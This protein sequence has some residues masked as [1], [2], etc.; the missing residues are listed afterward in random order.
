MFFGRDDERALIISNL[1][2]ARL[3]L[4]YAES[5]VGKTSLLRAGVAARLRTLAQRSVA[6][7]GSAGYVPVVFSSWRDDPTGEFVSEVRAAIRPFASGSIS[8]LPGAPLHE[9]IQTAA[10]ATD[11]TLLVILDQFEEYLLYSSREPRVGR[12]ADELAAC[13]NRGDLRA[14]FLIAVREDAYAGLG[15]LFLGKIG[16]LYGNYL[17]LEYLDRQAARHA[18]VRPIE[19]FNAAHLDTAPVQIEPALVDAVLDQVQTG[20][21]AFEHEGRG[22]LVFGNGAAREHDQI[23]TPYLQLVMSA[24][25]EHE[26]REGSQS[27]R[28][29]T[30]IELGGAERIVRSH[31]EEA[32]R[33]L[34]DEERDTAVE[35]FNHLVTPGGT[36]IAHTISDLADYSGRDFEQ[37]QA[38]IG[39]LA[40]GDQRILRPVPAAPGDDGRPRVEIFHDVLA[41]AILSWRSTQN[42]L[43]LEREKE[44]AEAAAGRERRRAQLFRA[45]ALAVTAL[46]VVA[47]VLA[48]LARVETSRAVR[49]QHLALSRQL[50]AAALPYIQRGPID[51]GALLSLEAFH[52]AATGGAR[53]SLVEAVQATAPII[54]YLGGHAAAVTSVAVS[55]NGKLIASVGA[56]GTMLIQDPATGRTEHTFRG[57]NKLWSVA[58]SPDGALLVAG[59]DDGTVTLW[60]V[61]TGRL[62][63][64]LREDSA[65]VYAVAFSPDAAMVASGGADHSVVLWDVRSGRRLR[66]LQVGRT[67]VDSVAFSP[68][69][70]TLASGGGDGRVI[71][72]GLNTGQPAHTL[73]RSRAAV[74]SVAFA[75]DGRT[76]ASAGDDNLVTLWN[77]VTARRRM[78]LRGQMSAVN[79]V[80]YSPDGGMLAAA[81]AG[82]AVTVWQPTTGRR[83]RTFSGQFAAIESVAFGPGGVL[84]SGGDDDHVIIW[85][86]QPASLERTLEENSQVAGVAFSPDGDVIAAGAGDA[87]TLRSATTGQLVRTFAGND[88]AVE[89]V[90]F[91]PDGRMLASANADSTVTLWNSATG[92]RERTLR[93]HTDFV[94]SVA[95]SPDGRTLASA[96]ADDAVVLWNPM[97][98]A[99][100]RTLRGHTDFVNGVAFSPD[101]RTLASASSD[102]S[103]ILWDVASGRRLR[104]L[105]GFTAAVQ[106]VAFSPN[107]R[108]LAAGGDDRTVTL[109]DPETGQSLGDPLSGSSGSLLSVAFSPNGRLLASAGA[110]PSA[111]LWDITSR[112]GLAIDGHSGPVEGLA[113]SPDG[114][115]LATA[116]LDGTVQVSGPLPASVPFGAVSARLCGVVHRSLLRSEWNEFLPD[117]PYR[118]TCP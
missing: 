22:A 87:V 32:M 40:A 95:F 29:S 72:W 100:E 70:A 51:R 52:Y 78:D 83:L 62:L 94:Y 75:P 1:R 31:L 91:S 30:L 28:L 76:L 27:L 57:G 21:V 109:W 2:A 26:Q 88:G 60:S 74:N 10:A 15:E 45:M 55:P 79:S 77:T 33:G 9:V 14:N 41:P 106:S 96:G 85:R 36:K 115:M 101:G 43:R 108:V 112:L 116:S 7:R 71:I 66:V 4:L 67:T 34:S 110:G 50:A 92:A 54:A 35:V 37:V 5:G 107:G 80:A 93:G 18:I 53:A 102:E 64:S 73:R 117:E 61:T 39:R 13:L 104:T 49:A 105:T 16:N 90:A 23:E 103:V 98:G 111:I 82:Q 118:R 20:R 68:D 8:E 38:L 17:H 99:R 114:H 81:G 89:H 47:I 46:L 44:A 42:A 58:F 69:R 59:G 6:E 84:A 113:F 24:L 97:T 65:P 48:V 11:A 25:W 19:R 86:T 63:A 12:F 3:T 56:D